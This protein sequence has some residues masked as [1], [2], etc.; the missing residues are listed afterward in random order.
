MRASPSTIADETDGRE[1]QLANECERQDD[2]SY[3]CA[4]CEIEHGP[5][6][7]IDEIDDAAAP[8]PVDDVGGRATERSPEPYTCSGGVE[9]VAVLGDHQ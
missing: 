3:D 6:T 1:N 7:E 9:K 2:A 8:Q 5:E 4:V